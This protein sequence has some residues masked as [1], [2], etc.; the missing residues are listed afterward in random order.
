M[1]CVCAAGVVP[2]QADERQAA[3]A[4]HVVAASGGPQ[5]LHLHDDARR[6]HGESA[7]PLPLAHAPALLPARRRHGGGCGSGSHRRGLVALRHLHPAPRH[8]PGPLAP[9]LAA[10]AAV[11]LPASRTVPVAGGAQQL[12]G[13]SFGGCGGSGCGRGG[14]RAPDQLGAMLVPEL[15]QQQPCGERARQPERQH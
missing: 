9:L 8:L 7:L 15:P 3:A 4:G 6:G 1:L 12:S 14:E 10:G 2:E 11:Q 5:F 13:S